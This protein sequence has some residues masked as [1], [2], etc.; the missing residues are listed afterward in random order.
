MKTWTTDGNSSFDWPGGKKKRNVLNI[1]QGFID[2]WTLLWI[3]E[4]LRPY[5]MRWLLP[6]PFLISPFSGSLSPSWHICILTPFL[7]GWGEVSLW[8]SQSLILFLFP[9]PLWWNVMTFASVLSMSNPS[10]THRHQ[11]DISKVNMPCHVPTQNPLVASWNFTSNHCSPGARFKRGG[12]VTVAGNPQPETS[13]W[14]PT[15]W[16]CA[17]LPTQ[18]VSKW[19]TCLQHTLRLLRRAWETS[20][21]GPPSASIASSQLRVLPRIVSLFFSHLLVCIACSSQDLFFNNKNLKLFKLEKLLGI[22]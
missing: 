16:E 3:P 17:S 14:Q 12:R 10:F 15:H 18:C 11:Q 7:G 2:M 20:V 6:W 13:L 4:W 22:F 5:C 21:L 1:L 19:S 8:H 9:P